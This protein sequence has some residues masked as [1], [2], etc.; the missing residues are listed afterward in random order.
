MKM[1]V[2]LETFALNMQPATTLSE[3]IIVRATQDLNLV[4]EGQCSRAWTN[5]VKVGGG[6][7]Q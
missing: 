4:E 5:P 3:A 2:W 7:D 1:N 6:F